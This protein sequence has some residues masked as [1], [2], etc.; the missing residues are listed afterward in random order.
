MEGQYSS[1]RHADM[2]RNVSR[3]VTSKLFL[4]EYPLGD[5]APVHVFLPLSPL[6]RVTVVTIDVFDTTLP[7]SQ[8]SLALANT[9]SVVSVV[10]QMLTISQR[11]FDR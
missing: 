1:P 10:F 6:F 4:Y 5:Q 9:G 7:D 2:R 8:L 3:R 11:A